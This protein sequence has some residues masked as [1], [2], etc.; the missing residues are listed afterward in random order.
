MS[1]GVA[2]HQLDLHCWHMRRRGRQTLRIASLST[3]P[4]LPLQRFIPS[5]PLRPLAANERRIFIE[6]VSAPLPG[7]PAH[8]PR[9]RCVIQD[10][11]GASRRYEAIR[12]FNDV[13]ELVRPSLHMHLDER[14]IGKPFSFLMI[15]GGRCRATQRNDRSHRVQ[16]D[17]KVSLKKSSLWWVCL[18]SVPCLNCPSGPW[19]GS[20]FFYVVREG[21]FDHHKRNDYTCQ[22]F[23]LLYPNIV[24]DSGELPAGYGST[25]H[26]KSVYD[27][28]VECFQHKGVYAR[29]GRWNA[30]HDRVLELSSDWHA[31]LY[32]VAIVGITRG[33]WTALEDTGLSLR[34]KGRQETSAE[35]DLPAQPVAEPEAQEPKT[36]K[37]SNAKV[38]SERDKCFNNLHYTATV[39]SDST[40]HKLCLAI[41]MLTSP[42]RIQF[43][44]DEVRCKTQ[45]GL[46]QW[47]YEETEGL[48]SHKLAAV[49]GALTS[50][51]NM[52]KLGFQDADD[53]I[54]EWCFDD[55]DYVA[56][57]AFAFSYNLVGQ[58]LLSI[59]AAKASPP[60][61]FTRLLHNDSRETTL[62]E[63]SVLFRY[64]AYYEQAA[65]RD[66]G[67][68]SALASMVWPDMQYCREVLVD[69]AETGF[70]AIPDHTMASIRGFA[71]GMEGTYMIEQLV[72]FLLGKEG[73]SRSHRMGRIHRWHCSTQCQV[74][75]AV[76][77]ARGEVDHRQHLGRQ[78]DEEF[79]ASH[80]RG[81]RGRLLLGPCGGGHIGRQG[82][83]ISEPGGICE[84]F[85]CDHGNGVLRH[86]LGEVPAE[87]LKHAVGARHRR[88]LQDFE[89][90]LRGG[91]SLAGGR[92]LVVGEGDQ[93]AAWQVLGEAH[94]REH[95]RETGLAVLHHD[96]PLRVEGLASKSFVSRVGGAHL[97]RGGGGPRHHFDA[98]DRAAGVA[99]LQRLGRLPE[100]ERSF[101]G[102]VGEVLGL[103]RLRGHP[104]G[105]GSVV[106]L[107][108]PTLVRCGEDWH[109]G[110]AHEQRCVGG[111]G[112]RG[113][114]QALGPEGPRDGGQLDCR[115]RRARDEAAGGEAGGEE[116]QAG[117]AKAE[118]G[119]A[120]RRGGAKRFERGGQ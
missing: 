61:S 22:L 73:A 78:C 90:G 100:V 88:L 104:G 83:A 48:A 68:G 27:G 41:A 98:N 95:F 76:R 30:W 14:S 105:V 50:A 17:C 116:T 19:M 10:L 77:P 45:Q 56:R 63:L 8:I 97:G 3:T 31:W 91:R 52:F 57:K 2:P 35:D 25:E 110:Y 34:P 81:Q 28:L 115:G 12:E 59:G 70:K 109:L 75:G 103:A 5:A 112:R 96:G 80:V 9:F 120:G 39:L 20:A 85:V 6:D 4:C 7:V 23:K 93:S 40:L 79:A 36:G 21:F 24:R 84:G 87:L 11:S 102:Q 99:P 117:R 44:K 72:N 101:L 16:N 58:R 42:V 118:P 106:G 69:L 114:Q 46:L 107:H 29:L 15:S 67:I 26:Q 37:Q 51:E 89:E 49:F 54:P 113:A 119:C 62:S 86:G 92:L 65:I 53:N 43:G 94:H 55:D 60:F 18:E 32:G 38:K 64:L 1:T 33:W 13:G 47:W 66:K 82:L 71:L 111:R 108:L 74:V